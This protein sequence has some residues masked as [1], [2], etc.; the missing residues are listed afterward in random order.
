M[1]EIVNL[2][3]RE[4]ELERNAEREGDLELISGESSPVNLGDT[5]SGDVK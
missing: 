2:R 4:P 3:G 1:R 5:I